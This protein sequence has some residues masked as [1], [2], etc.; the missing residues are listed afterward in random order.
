M[1]KVLF[2]LVIST[3]LAFSAAAQK[4]YTW[5]T[6]HIQITVPRDFRVLTNTNHDF[7]MKGDGM[8]LSMHIFEKNVAIDDLDDATIAGALGVIA[9]WDGR[10]PGSTDFQACRPTLW[11]HDGFAR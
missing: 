4:T 6:Y 8:E 5:D 9:L 3:L 2:T 10:S 11:P 1:K 7:D